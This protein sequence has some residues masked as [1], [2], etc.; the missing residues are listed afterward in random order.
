MRAAYNN[1][2]NWQ[3]RGVGSVNSGQSRHIQH[4]QFSPSERI[5][6]VIEGT[7][8]LKGKPSGPGVRFAFYAAC[9][10]LNSLK[11]RRPKPRT[12]PSCC[13]RSAAARLPRKRA[14]VWPWIAFTTR[15]G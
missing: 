13:M 5:A 4:T 7:S 10:G 1:A 15:G 11:V 9:M 8:G 12:A 2:P 3:G 6:H 14:L